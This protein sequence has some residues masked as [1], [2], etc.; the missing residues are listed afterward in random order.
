MKER[1]E[2]IV[3]ADEVKKHSP[4]HNSIPDSNTFDSISSDNSTNP[5][6]TDVFE[7]SP[8]SSTD[9]SSERR[10]SLFVSNDLH[11]RDQPAAR[12][13]TSRFSQATTTGRSLSEPSQSPWAGQM[14]RPLPEILP[15]GT[16]LQGS[17]PPSAS[18][19]LNSCHSRNLSQ[20]SAMSGAPSI[21]PSLLP[22]L[23]RDI[24]SP[25]PEVGIAAVIPIRRSGSSSPA[26]PAVVEEDTVLIRRNA[27]EFSSVS[28]NAAFGGTPPGLK[29]PAETFSRKRQGMTSPPLGGLFSLPNITI[30]KTRKS[31][32][33]S[34]CAT[35][36]KT[37]ILNEDSDQDHENTSALSLTES[38]WMCRTPSPVRNDPEHVRVEKIWSPPPGHRTSKE[39]SRTSSGGF[40]KRAKDWYESVRSSAE[41]ESPLNKSAIRTRSGNWI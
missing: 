1:R 18:G 20:G 8:E 30:R 7:D 5:W 6:I 23:D 25:E 40:K 10:L 4:K 24:Y 16:S 12:V 17:R 32:F 38:E 11:S 28:S 33:K 39:G 15:R 41:P 9:S 29:T 37:D 19:S 14:A 26:T 3:P 2:G 35:L 34:P 31:P 36:S 21:T 22:Y 13:P 27:K